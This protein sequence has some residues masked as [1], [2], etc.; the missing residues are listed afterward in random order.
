MKRLLATVA[1]AGSVMLASA[2]NND[3]IYGNAHEAEDFLSQ[4]AQFASHPDPNFY[5][6]LCI[7]QSNMEGPFPAD[8]IDYEGV[9][10]RFLVM[11]TMDFN[12]GEGRYRG[13]G[14]KKYEWDVAVPPLCRPNTGLSCADY[15]GRT[16]AESLP[17]SIK[18][19]V[20]HVAIGGCKI[21]HLFKEYDPAEVQKEAGWFQ[22]FMRA[23][24]NL[25]YI[26]LIDCALRAQKQGVIKGILL[27]Q[28]C[29]NTGDPK[30][31][32]KVNKVYN[33]I[34]RDLSLKAEDCPLVAGELV[35]GEMGGKCSSHNPIINQLPSVI[36]NSAVVSSEGLTC[37][38]DGLHFSLEGFREIGK[39]YAEA[40]M[41]LNGIQPIVKEQPAP[42]PQKGK[43]RKGKK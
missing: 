15:F 31:P 42:E 23:Y 19:G 12:K 1:L 35:R 8:S 27:H 25:P 11:P 26:R 39:R 30:W 4:S 9:S 22:G 3:H 24:D 29:S 34:L 32:A 33:D 20:V 40:M 41:K 14:R 17:D 10:E 38:P 13:E 2:Q 21:E 6:Y 36:K 28:G 16:M 18:V 5:I 37:Q 7:G 43:G